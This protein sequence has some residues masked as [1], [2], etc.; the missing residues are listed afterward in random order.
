MRTS[1]ELQRRAEASVPPIFCWT[2]MGSEAGQGLSDIVRRKDLERQCGRGLFA[3]GIGNSVGPA[4][5][6]ARAA[7]RMPE[8]FALFTPMKSRPKAIDASPAQIVMWMSYYAGADHIATLPSHM[9]I[10]SRGQAGSGTE[11]RVHYALFCRSD[12]SLLD[13][14]DHGAIDQRAVSNLVSSNPVGASQVT[15]VVRHDQSLASKATYPVLFKAKLA[16]AGFVR[17]A[18]PVRLEGDLFALYADVC[19]ATSRSEWAHRISDL[20]AAALGLAHQQ[21]QLELID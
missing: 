11:K 6:Y 1:L 10:T 19:S 4:I 20:K 8:L 5:E 13:Q 15:S 14:R 3:W 9:L 21:Q 2:K 16:E 12:D 18:N 7:E 17:L